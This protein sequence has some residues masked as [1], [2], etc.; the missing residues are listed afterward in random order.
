MIYI[1]YKIMLGSDKTGNDSELQITSKDIIEQLK[2]LRK[3]KKFIIVENLAT[4]YLEQKPADDAV[5]TIYAK[6]L[7]ESKKTYDA[8]DQAKII[9]KREPHDS[10]MQIFLANCYLSIRQPMKAIECLK[11]VLVYDRDNAVAVKELANAY[12]DTNQKRSALG[13]YEKLAEFLESSYEQ[14]ENKARIADIRADFDEYDL[15]IK[16][17][18]EILEIY[19]NDF[20]FR[21]RLIELYKA[22]LNYAPLINSA[23]EILNSHTND[24]NSLWA[25]QMLMDVYDTM[26]NYERALEFAHMIKEHPLSDK[27]QINRTISE[28][29]IKE[30]KTDDS[31]SLLLTLV[32][33]EPNNIELRKALANAYEADN[34]FE[35]ATDVYKKILDDASAKDIENV[36]FEIS[37][38]Y[39]NWGTYFFLNGDNA[40]CFKCFTIALQYCSTNPDI[41]ARLGNINKL[42]KNFNESISQYKKAIEF[43]EKNSEYYYEMA[44]SYK[45]IDSIY[46]EKK[47]Y[48]KCLEYNPNNTKAYFKL[49]LICASQNNFNDAISNLRK[50]VELDNNFVEAKHK[51]ALYLEHQG[52]KDGAVK[53]YEEILK[54]N[55]ENQEIAANLKILK[56][57]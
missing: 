56:G 14:A 54:S 8:I 2:I 29:L 4:K 25:M 52:D 47:A 43:D 39:S 16:Q 31:I 21:K 41:Y 23:T 18:E 53:L 57:K 40:E 48:Q 42:I 26:Q 27:S 28:I 50:A 30:G 49:A 19:P 3:Q 35:Q 10:N 17:Y 1:L 15:A 38:I 36:H 24:E 51:L 34:N 44:E 20:R 46:E 45:E 33:K 32:E 5:R 37:N 22:T 13:M 55:P 7:H 9:L 11:S 12:F 6:A